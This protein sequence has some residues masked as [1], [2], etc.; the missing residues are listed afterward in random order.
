LFTD[1]SSW[2]AH[3]HTQ[4]EPPDFSRQ[5]LLP[6]ALNHPG[7]GVTWLDWDQDG[8]DD[9]LLSGG[10][11]RAWSV[12][13]N[14]QGTR[15][16]ASATSTATS[17][18]PGNTLSVIPWSTQAVLSVNARPSS[19]PSGPSLVT[20]HRRPQAGTVG[21]LPTQDSQ[22][23][24][25][26][27]ADIDSDGDLDVF[28]GG[29]HVPDRYPTAAV[30][31]VFLNQNQTLVPAED[32][33]P[34]LRNAGM[35]S[36]AV[37]TDLDLDGQP[38]LVLACD[39]GPIRIF[40][41]RRGR[42]TEA[43]QAWA[44]EEWSGCWAGIAAG[45]FNEDGRPDLIVSNLGRNT[46]HAIPGPGMW[47]LDALDTDEDG[48]LEIIESHR[49]I[50][51]DDF[52]PWRGLD[53]LGRAVP[54]FLQRFPTYRSFGNATV[55]ALLQGLGPPVITVEARALDH[56]LFLN[57]GDHFESQ[58]L[59]PQAQFAPGFG[60]AVA[61]FDG[62]GHLDAFLAQNTF[63]LDLD[64]GRADA[65]TGLCLLGNGKGGFR[66]LSPAESG[67][68]LHS[69]QRGVAVADFNRDG[70]PDLCVAQNNGTTALLRN[71][72]GKPGLRVRVQGPPENPHAIGACL[73]MQIDGAATG[74]AREVRTGS[75]YLSA[76]ST[77]LVFP[78]TARASS[79]EIRWPG[80]RK[81][82]QPIPV[83][84]RDLTVAP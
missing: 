39:W 9:L 70:R 66:A 15:F 79:L 59:P 73:R 4:P 72:G 62:D 14:D 40:S 49:P 26:A 2:L 3:A 76:D 54:S 80:G 17:P 19:Q 21:S 16:S 20:L 12:Y 35:V 11:G 68:T 30:S 18:N 10:P 82:V 47:R 13:R 50:G 53:V 60:I 65:G 25:V 1:V 8:W 83:D 43:T 48:A 38:E 51:T 24:P 34:E 84:A 78:A 44:M 69:A 55:A 22:P 77:T 28:L 45:D 61:D 81:T 42:F 71:A 33:P 64:S 41:N 5:T 67:V 23:G 29:R 32:L 31:Q 7:P 57:R 56:R 46:R 75:G 6:R 36:G 63:D 37:F 74:P 58:P 52:L 27:V